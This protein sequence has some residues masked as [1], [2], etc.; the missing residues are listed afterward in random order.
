M[1]DVPSW[2][3]CCKLTF[4]DFPEDLILMHMQETCKIFLFW[5]GHTLPIACRAGII[6]LLQLLQNIINANTFDPRITQICHFSG[7][8]LSQGMRTWSL[9]CQ[10]W[11]PFQINTCY[12]YNLVLKEAHAAF[13]VVASLVHGRSYLATNNKLLRMVG[14]ISNLWKWTWEKQKLLFCFN[15]RLWLGVSYF[16]GQQYK[17][18]WT[19]RAC[20]IWIHS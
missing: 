1:G 13:L 11:E 17:A 10:H 5:N 8:L 16:N 9:A 19:H 12:C 2:G 4:W 14:C 7:Q 18:L 15:L 6:Q 20:F 3:T